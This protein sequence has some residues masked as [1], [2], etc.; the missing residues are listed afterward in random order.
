MGSLYELRV[1]AIA[2]PRARVRVARWLAQR[3]PA[4]EPAAIE[5]GLRGAA[6]LARVE[7]D[8]AEAPAVLR[9]LYA[10]GAPPAA[11][12]L[13][14]ARLVARSDRDED[15]A[16]RGFDVFG[17][18]GG[19]VPTW[20]WWAFLLGPVWYFRKGIYAKGTVILVLVIYPF[21]SLPVTVL[22]SLLVFLYC[23]VAAN[24]DYY[25]LRVKRTQWW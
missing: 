15:A 6:Y 12:V 23:G 14:P 4:Q 19:F 7:L 21:W 11:V 25:L 3:F 9:E 10:A 18:H 13:L 1:A 24:W 17:H 2:D 8:E 20:N 5:R 16:V 22:V